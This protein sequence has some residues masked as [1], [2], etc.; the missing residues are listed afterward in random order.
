MLVKLSLCRLLAR[1]DAQKLI[2]W[3]NCGVHVL[4]HAMDLY[5]KQ[6]MEMKE[7][8]VV[9]EGITS[10][11]RRLEEKEM[12]VVCGEMAASET[13]LEEKT[14]DFNNG[15]VK[16]PDSTVDV[17]MEQAP[18][19][20]AGVDEEVETTEA[21]GKLEDIASTGSQEEVKC[22]ENPEESLPNSNSI[23]VDMIDA[24]QLVVNLEAEKDTIF[25]A[26]DNTPVN[27]SDKFNNI[28]IKGIAKGNDSTRCG[29]GNSCFDNAV[30]G[31]LSFPEEIP[32]TCEGLMP[33]SIGSE[34]LILSQ[35][36]HSPESTH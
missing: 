30:S 1:N 11:E 29:V 10:S 6:R 7:M 17:E 2:A 14:F 36:H 26:K 16:V 8:Q 13:K 19:K 31:P 24:E 5:K 9:S 3:Y 32:E 27:D 20:T 23:E 35:I 34:S 33:V 28:D 18:I 4:Q 21:L 22:L 15:E 12:E 25:I